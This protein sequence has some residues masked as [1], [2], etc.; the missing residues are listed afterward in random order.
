[1]C[2]G[3]KKR[4]ASFSECGHF[5][6]A[7]ELDAGAEQHQF[8]PLLGT[9]LI[10]QSVEFG[11]RNTLQLTCACQWPGPRSHLPYPP[12]HQE[13]IHESTGVYLERRRGQPRLLSHGCCA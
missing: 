1:M 13:F 6:P 9:D 7:A 8:R 10:E 2:G 3:E 12:A 4:L 11:G 5:S